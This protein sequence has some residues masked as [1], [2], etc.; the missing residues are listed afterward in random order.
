MVSKAIPLF[1]LMLTTLLIGCGKNAHKET[2]KFVVEWADKTLVFPE[3]MQTIYGEN[4]QE[5]T[6]DF[7]I[8]AYFDSLGCTGCRMR[9]PHWKQFM[10]SV[11]TMVGKD[12]VSL[13]LIAETNNLDKIRK[14]ESNE[15]FP[16]LIINDSAGIFRKL[17]NLPDDTQKQTFLLDEKHKVLLIGNPTY[18]KGMR[19]LYLSHFGDV[20]KSFVDEDYYNV[21]GEYDFGTIP[22]YKEV[23]HEFNITNVYPDTLRLREITTSCDCTS[24]TASLDVIPPDA[25]FEV[26]VSFKD[27]IAGDFL[28]SVTLKYKDS[29]PD[30]ILEISGIIK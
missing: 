17:N 5:P 12:K 16:Y 14:L 10:R 1:L 20:Q 24:A 21:I 4:V 29:I 3:N 27:S 11:E 8:I 25:T 28:R 2:E 19:K 7:T 23:S 6:T 9:M 22:P 18:N 30:Q 15:G 13:M 26:K